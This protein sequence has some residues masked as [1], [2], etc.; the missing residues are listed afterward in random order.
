MEFTILFVL[1]IGWPVN[2]W[3]K[4]CYIFSLVHQQCFLRGL[5]VSLFLQLIGVFFCETYHSY[6]VVQYFFQ[7]LGRGSLA[8]LILQSELGVVCQCYF[9]GY[10]LLYTGWFFLTEEDSN[11]NL[12][13]WWFEFP[14][15]WS[16]EDWR[17]LEY[18]YFTQYVCCDFTW[19]ISFICFFFSSRRRHT[20][21]LCDWSS[22]VCSS[23]LNCCI[24]FHLLLGVCKF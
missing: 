4:V 16:R 15:K 19:N 14:G 5:W 12:M 11:W 6:A 7:C 10:E 1:K 20:R 8:S 23:D 3:F 9:P 24:E 18:V 13:C 22:D 21:S 2:L 17:P